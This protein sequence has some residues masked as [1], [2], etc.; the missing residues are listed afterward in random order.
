M[1]KLLFIAFLITGFQLAGLGMGQLTEIV[2]FASA[3]EARKLLATEDDFTDS[4]GQIDLDSRMRKPNSTR[5]ELMKMI[6]EQAR[7]WTQKEIDLVK[8]I[9][10][11]TDLII[12]IE[13]YHLDFPDT[14][15]FVKTTF[16]EA[17]VNGYAYT[18]QNY[19]VLNEEAI[20]QYNPQLQHTVIHQLFHLLTMNNKDFRLDMYKIIGCEKMDDITFPDDLNDKILTN[21]DAVYTDSYIKLMH[22]DLQVECMVIVYLEK[23][24]DGGNILEY[25]KIG[26]LKL[27]GSG[28]TKEIAYDDGKPVIYSLNEVSGFFEQVGRNTDYIVHPEMILAENFT[29]AILKETG[30]PDQDLVRA[31]RGRLKY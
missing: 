22:N 14:I 30:L 21:P 10:D 9:L 4:W 12:A 27:E 25:T 1:R 19:V 28:T 11:D 26:F 5:D 31:V 13:K 20:T 2:R 3:E 8:R 18:R 24:Y 23:P 16:A 6:P 7:E 17:S 15:F 29:F